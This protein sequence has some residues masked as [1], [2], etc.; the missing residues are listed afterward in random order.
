MKVQEPL[1]SINIYLSWQCLALRPQMWI[2]VLFLF[3]HEPRSFFSEPR[4]YL[5]KPTF[6]CLSQ[7]LISN[8]DIEQFLVCCKNSET[9]SK[10]NITRQVHNLFQDLMNN[11]I[12]LGFDF[13]T[14]LS[15]LSIP[16]IRVST[17]ILVLG[18]CPDHQQSRTV[19]GFSVTSLKLFKIKICF[20]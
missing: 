9:K 2:S 19:F 10:S 6:G 20:H 3:S 15:Y 5:L 4:S 11:F 16:K 17:K 8:N 12:F 7:T 1:Q 13:F 18:W 14:I